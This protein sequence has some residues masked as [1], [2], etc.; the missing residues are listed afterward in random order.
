MSLATMTHAGGGGGG[1]TV[2][3]PD[4][5]S[6]VEQY[7]CKVCA[8]GDDEERMLLCDGCDDAYHTYCL[9]PPLKD[10][11]PGDWLCPVCIAK[12]G[13]LPIYLNVSRDYFLPSFA[14]FSL[15]RGM[16]GRCMVVSLVV[17]HPPA[18]GKV[19]VSNLI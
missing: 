5:D 16:I 11:P 19:V 15:R 14:L 12:V 7:F 17:S 4:E 1:V 18:S 9:N 13:Y 2:N 8:G 3:D 10:I 6:K